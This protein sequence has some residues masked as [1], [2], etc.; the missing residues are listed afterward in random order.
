MNIEEKQE[1]EEK[2]DEA[3]TDDDLDQVR[4]GEDEDENNLAETFADAPHTDQEEN[5]N[6][7]EQ[8]EEEEKKTR[9]KKRRNH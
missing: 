8:E 3:F 4:M 9:R 5:N 6:N 1:K 2:E 7:S